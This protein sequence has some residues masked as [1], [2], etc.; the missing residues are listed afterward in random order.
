MPPAPTPVPR[1]STAASSASAST[2]PSAVARSMSMA[3]APSTWVPTASASA[4]SL[5]AEPARSLLAPAPSPRMWASS[6]ITRVIPIF[7]SSL[8]VLEASSKLR[9]TP[10]LSPVP[11][12]SPVRS[13]S[14]PARSPWPPL[15]TLAMPA[16]RWEPRSM[17]SQPRF[18][19]AAALPRV[20]S[21]TLAL[22]RPRIAP[23]A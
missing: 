4:S 3:V 15:A 18:A 20:L 19:S 23:S 2:T 5:P 1:T 6:S 12:P 16:A 7:R 9:A 11:I 10:S 8:R 14:R 13:K 17:P 21:P 22:A